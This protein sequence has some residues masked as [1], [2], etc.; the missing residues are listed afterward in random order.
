MLLC[1]LCGLC[2]ALLMVL[3]ERG[4]DAE[5]AFI[6]LSAALTLLAFCINCAGWSRVVNAA[7]RVAAR[8]SV[9]VAP[10]RTSPHQDLEHAKA[11]HPPAAGDGHG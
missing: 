1:E 2:V 8:I 5:V 9:H 7:T 3:S 6:L 11:Q 4:D 10:A